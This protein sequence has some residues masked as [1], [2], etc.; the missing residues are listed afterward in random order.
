MV[1]L[2][3]HW[4]KEQVLYLECSLLGSESQNPLREPFLTI[5]WAHPP[6][7]LFKAFSQIPGNQISAY[8]TFLLCFNFNS[9][10][11]L[12]CTVSLIVR[13]RAGFPLALHLR[14]KVTHY[15]VPFFSPS[16]SPSRLVYFLVS[17]ETQ[18]VCDSDFLHKCMLYKQLLISL[19]ELHIFW[20]DWLFGKVLSLLHAKTKR[21]WSKCW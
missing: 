19:H 4:E 6:G 14:I 17:V 9:L 16:W 15:Q 13:G 21:L 12:L 1:K 10:L 8:Q 11:L 18:C 7:C 3:K 20:D 2:I 5:T